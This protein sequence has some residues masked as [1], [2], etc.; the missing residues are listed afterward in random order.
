MSLQYAVIW[1]G[2]PQLGSSWARLLRECRCSAHG[3][4]LIKYLTSKHLQRK[5]IGRAS[6]LW[7]DRLAA[8]PI[9]FSVE[10]SL[11][12]SGVERDI[13]PKTRQLPMEATLEYRFQQDWREIPNMVA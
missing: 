3:P 10:R 9:I 7:L 2:Q 5:V 8:M 6:M 1:T 4:G 13:S 12:T 11:C